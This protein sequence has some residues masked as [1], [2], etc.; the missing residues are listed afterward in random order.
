MRGNSLVRPRPKAND[1]LM[2]RLDR[3]GKAVLTQ[4]ARLRHISV[5]DYVR[6]VMLIQ[7][8]KDVAAAQTRTIQM[9][10]VAQLAFWKALHAPPKLT[11]N[12]QRLG[13]IMRGEA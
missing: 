13:R 8:R 10:P 4:A 3:A 5:S 7:A 1:T 2:V 11:K 6:E 12:Q 9:T